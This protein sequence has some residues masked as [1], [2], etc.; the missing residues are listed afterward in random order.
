[1]LNAGVSIIRALQSVPKTGKYGR[2]FSRIEQDVSRGSSIS[3]AAQNHRKAFQKLDL[4]LIRVGEETGQLSEMFE[5][6]SDWY[7]FRQRM[8]RT[9][10]SGLALPILLIHALAL[11]GPIVPFAVSG[12]DGSVYL[13][14]FLKIIAIFY[15]PAAVILAIIYLTPKRG[16]LRW[17]LDV[18]VIGMP[19]LGKAVRE[20][21]LSRYTKIFS[22]TYRAGVPI[23]QC[24]EMATET[25]SNRVMVR[26]LEGAVQ[27]GRDGQEMSLGFSR[28]LPA[29][30]INVWQVGEESGELDNATWHLAKM[31][32]D[33][34]EMR[35]KIIAE[36]VPRMIYAIVSGV[37][38]YY[39]IK[40]AG[41]IYGN[42]I[43]L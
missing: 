2:L 20:L 6:L 22:I 35:F 18:F 17:M 36:W 13:R 32:T 31:H 1:M 30:F 12:F 28:G 16:P 19:M 41:M 29:E 38:I 26:R 7:A 9:I 24:A 40:A 14:E 43:G 3:D 21:E 4:V 11:I 15:I 37:I 34:S 33:N 42:L 27:K 5:H 25:V 39:I 23:I 10:R 8:N